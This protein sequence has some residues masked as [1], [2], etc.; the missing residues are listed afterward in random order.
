ME[1]LL[2]CNFC[3]VA[4]NQS[5]LL[6]C[7]F[8]VFKFNFVFFLSYKLFILSNYCILPVLFIF[9]YWCNLLV[10]FIFLYCLYSSCNVY[11]LV[12]LV[13]FLSS[14]YSCI[15]CILLVLFIFLYWLYLACHVYILVLVFFFLSC[16]YSCSG[17]I[18]LF[19]FI[20][21]FWF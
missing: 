9:L 15:G 18:F 16:L 20:F 17:S 3:S 1:F 7:N 19:Q 14:L 13:F 5:N 8:L 11:F 10:L 4:I 12:L 21:L 6:N 2:F